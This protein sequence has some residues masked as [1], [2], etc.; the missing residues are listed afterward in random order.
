VSL[1]RVLRTAATTLTKTMYDGET[2]TDASSAVT[3]A[4]TR[5]DGT[6]VNTGTATKPPATTGIYTYILPGGP[7][8]PSS[9]TWQLDWLTV[10]WSCTLAGAAVTFTDRVEVVGGYLFGL[11]EA[12]ASDPSLGNANST[13]YPA[14]LLAVKRLE[15]E[16]ECER[17][18][19]QAFVPR[20]RRALLNGSGRDALATADA[21]LRAPVRAASVAYLTGQ[22]LTALSAGEVAQLAPTPDGLI[23][24]PSGQVW[25]SGMNNVRVEYEYGLDSPPPDLVD[26]ALLRLKSLLNR[27]RSGVPD[28]V[29][30]YSNEAGTF[31]ISM[32]GRDKTGIPDVDA[33]YESYASPIPGFA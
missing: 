31:R 6:V 16:I 32:P 14:A 18:C 11:A 22:T 15:V 30:S 2:P 5:P 23:M 19:G 13:T 25:P 20:F 21:W 12:R 28:R 9:V 29:S 24:R 26:A 4:I 10:T 8:S 27:P 3:V 1:T 7:T 17:I 33:V